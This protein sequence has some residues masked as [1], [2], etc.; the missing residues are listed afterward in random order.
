[1]TEENQE[2]LSQNNSAASD[3]R[4]KYPLPPNTSRVDY[5]YC[6]LLGSGIMIY[7]VENK[8]WNQKC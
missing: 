7:F 6:K 5:R 3:S 4:T 2:N 1:M 8:V